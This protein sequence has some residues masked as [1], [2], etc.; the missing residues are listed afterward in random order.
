[1]C[2]HLIVI[3]LVM[4]LAAPALAAEPNTDQ[5]KPIEGIGPTDPVTVVGEGF[6]F[7]EGPAADA[8]GRLYFTD[9]FAGRV[10]RV[11]DDGT[12]E[13]LLDD[14]QGINGLM[15]D[16]AGTLFGCQG[17]AGRIVKVDVDTKKITPFASEYQG[18]RFNAPNDL[19][20]DSVGGVYFTDPQFGQASQDKAAFYYAAADG[21][22]TRL[23]DDLNFPNG[24]LLSPDETKLYVLPYRSA[25]VM[26]YD[27]KSPGVIGQG[28]V[29]CKMASVEKFPQRGGDGMTI[30]SKGNLYLTVPAASSIQVVDPAGETLGVIPVPKT[31][32]NCAFSGKDLKTLV[33]TTPS[34]VY[35]MPMAVAGHRHG[36]LKK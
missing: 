18:K 6:R 11:A 24:I 26:V 10:H 35:A 19:V 25:D 27:I 9:V 36:R 12:V 16:A 5:P 7:T 4:V 30:D 17:R 2:R 34:T 14:S 32:T 15:F 13:T 22:V 21:T 20:V 29:F 28:R 3:T 33:V 23:G 31:P 1:M 8:D